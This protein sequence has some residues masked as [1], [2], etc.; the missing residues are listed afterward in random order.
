LRAGISRRSGQVFVPKQGW[1]V[2][3]RDPG[4]ITF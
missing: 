3:S 1:F 4:L 2:T